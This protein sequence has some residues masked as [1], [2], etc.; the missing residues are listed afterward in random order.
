M[1]ARNNLIKVLVCMR[2]GN[3][4]FGKLKLVMEIRDRK[5]G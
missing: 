4:L 2:D 3:W 5:L 1:R